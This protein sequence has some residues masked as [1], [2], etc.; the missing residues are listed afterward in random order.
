MDRASGGGLSILKLMQV[1]IESFVCHKS[2]VAAGFNDPAPI[3]DDDPI[4]V[5]DC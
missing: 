4:C 2:L 5:A 1:E 3:E